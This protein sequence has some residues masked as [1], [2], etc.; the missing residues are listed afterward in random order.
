M[1]GTSAGGVE[2]LRSLAAALPIDF[3]ASVFVVLHVGSHKSRLPEVLNQ[4]GPLRA[5]HPKNGDPI[6]P[7][8]IVAPPDQHLL[9]EVGHVHGGGHK[10]RHVARQQRS[11][12]PAFS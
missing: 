3:K 2:A 6:R 7:G 4:S 9:V 11:Y 10:S 8:Q 5:V 12:L 1:V